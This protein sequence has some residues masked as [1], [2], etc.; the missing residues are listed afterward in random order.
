MSLI[1][2]LG[3]TTILNEA[4]DDIFDI[5][6]EVDAQIKRVENRIAKK[7]E[8]QNQQQEDNQAENQQQEETEQDL[9]N[10]ENDNVDN[11]DDENN[12]P[13]SSEQDNTQDNAEQ[14]GEYIDNQSE[15]IPEDYEPKQTIP[16]LKILST[17]SDNEYKLSNIKVMEQFRELRQKVDSLINNILRTITTKTSRQRQIVNIVHKNLYDMTEDIDNYILYRDNGVYEENSIAYLTY[18]KRYQI[19]TKIIRYIIEENSKSSE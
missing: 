15:D 19:A 9:E 17:V 13:N 4:N 16:E 12:I 8:Q 2:S 18:L 7:E 5:D 14:D 11:Q 10:P 3:N 6:K 1:G